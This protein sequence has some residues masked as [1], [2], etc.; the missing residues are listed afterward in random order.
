MG[1]R[2]LEVTGLNSPIPDPPIL[3]PPLFLKNR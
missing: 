3:R 2:S 1:V